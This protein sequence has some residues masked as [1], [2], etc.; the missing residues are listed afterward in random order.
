MFWWPTVLTLSYTVKR[1]ITNKWIISILLQYNAILYITIQY[2][3]YNIAL[4]QLNIK[5]YY[6]QIKIKVYDKLFKFFSK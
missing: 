6:V 2:L 4:Q 3:Y 1:L 5:K